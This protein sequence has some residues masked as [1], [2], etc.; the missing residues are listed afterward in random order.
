[1]CNVFYKLNSKS[2]NGLLAFGDLSIELFRNLRIKSRVIYFQ[3]D[4]Y[5]SRVYQLESDVSGVFTSTALYGK[6]WRWYGLLSYRVFNLFDLSLKYA[7]FYRDD[8]KKIG[9]GY[10]EIPTNLAKSLTLQI[11]MK[12]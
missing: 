1:M 3:T 10:D 8:L 5:D 12:F 9:S 6:G 4:S 7:E 11:E 2:E